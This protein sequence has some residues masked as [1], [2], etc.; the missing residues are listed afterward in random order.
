MSRID[1]AMVLAAGFGKR[2]RPLTDTRPKP[3]IEVAGRTLLDR[4]LDRIADAGIP[5]A[6][7]NVHYLADQIE[8]AVKHRRTP[9]IAISDER[10]RVLETGGGVKRALP[11]LGEAFLVHN[12]D[13]IWTETRSNIARLVQ[14]FDPDTTD[15]LLLLAPVQGSIGYD[16]S[17]DFDMGPGNRLARRSAPK[18]PFVFAGVSVLSA[19]LFEGVGDDAFSLNAIFDKAAAGNRLHGMVLDGIWMHVGTPE[20]VRAAEDCLLRFHS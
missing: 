11:L 15:A 2:M 13:T 7:V 14:A 18:A 5:R 20:A 9:A 3:L 1:T 8:A 16:G 17:G 4:V 6:V 12:A 10:D 19:A